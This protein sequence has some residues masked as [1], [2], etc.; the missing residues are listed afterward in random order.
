MMTKRFDELMTAILGLVLIE[1]PIGSSCRE[2][3]H[4]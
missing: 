1:L 4:V 3:G 2:G